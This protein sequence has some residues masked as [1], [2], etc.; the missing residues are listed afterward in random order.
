VGRAESGAALS[1]GVM[2]DKEFVKQVELSLLRQMVKML[3]EKKRDRDG[4]LVVMN[5]PVD[6]ESLS[7][8]LTEDVDRVVDWDPPC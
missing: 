8:M 3:R 6:D 1:G 2:E 7:F 4:A 5:V